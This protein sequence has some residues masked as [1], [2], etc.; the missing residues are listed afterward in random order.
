MSAAGEGVEK[1][2]KKKGRDIDPGTFPPLGALPHMRNSKQVVAHLITLMG[3]GRK[4]AECIALF[5]CNCL[6]LVPVD[7]HVWKLAKRHYGIMDNSLTPKVYDDIFD[8]FHGT[9]GDKAG[10]AHS[11][12]FAA[13]LRKM[14]KNLAIPEEQDKK[15][16][17]MNK[18]MTKPTISAAMKQF[19]RTGSRKNMTRVQDKRNKKWGVK[20]KTTAWLRQTGC[21]QASDHV[22]KKATW[23]TPLLKAHTTISL[24]DD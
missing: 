6:E 8:R 23:G 12:L 13:E 16:V 14:S 10:W 1:V 18:N 22:V 20:L 9:F 24:M 7:T 2:S 4:V 19:S 21:E 5:S 15:P 3:I 11:V 17:G